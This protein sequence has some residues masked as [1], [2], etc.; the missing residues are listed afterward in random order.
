MTPEEREALWRRYEELGEK[1]NAQT[2]WGAATS[3]MLE[4]R[5]AILRNLRLNK[6]PRNGNYLGD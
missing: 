3:V 6:K 1:L 4:E 5:Q 2:S